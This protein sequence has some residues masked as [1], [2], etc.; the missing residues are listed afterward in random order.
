[1]TAEQCLEWA[2]HN[3]RVGKPG[4]VA[5]WLERATELENKR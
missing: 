1:M 2:E 3:E 4:M 5:W